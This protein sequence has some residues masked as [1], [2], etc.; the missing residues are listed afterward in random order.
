MQTK[1]RDKKV[2]RT[3]EISQFFIQSHKSRKFQERYKKNECPN[4]QSRF[5]FDVNLKPITSIRPFN[6]FNEV[7]C[8]GIAKLMVKATRELTGDLSDWKFSKKDSLQDLILRCAFRLKDRAHVDHID[9]IE[10]APNEYAL[11]LKRY[12]SSRDK[13]FSIELDR[14]F[15][16]RDKNRLLFEVI[17]SF[18]KGLP[19][20]S[21]FDLNSPMVE[22]C[23]SFLLDEFDYC[24]EIEN[25]L[26]KVKSLDGSVYFLKRNFRVY[27]SHVESDWSKQLRYYRPRKQVYKDIK[28]ILLKSVSIDFS[29]INKVTIYDDRECDFDHRDTFLVSDHNN[30]DFVSQYIDMMNQLSADNDVLSTFSF[31]CIDSNVVERFDENLLQKISELE[32]FV[33]ELNDLL[34]KL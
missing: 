17:L 7:D 14:V 20:Q 21:M 31:A 19:F 8:E 34:N 16:L 25:T 3:Q 11:L 30:S 1:T 15:K 27:H 22:W 4:V 32:D 29:C 13:V 24:D 33:C 6:G 12:L 5:L 2:Q 28:A 26:E 18:V 9:T 10:I 23:W